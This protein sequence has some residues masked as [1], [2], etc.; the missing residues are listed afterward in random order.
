MVSNFK[1]YSFKN[2]DIKGRVPFVA[3]L[4]IVV[5]FSIIFIDPARVLFAMAFVYALSGPVM[6]VLGKRFD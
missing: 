5:V 2:F 1:Y 6:F 3:L 4:A